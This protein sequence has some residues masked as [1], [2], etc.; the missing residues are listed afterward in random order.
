MGDGHHGHHKRA[1][2]LFRNQRNL[3]I[4]FFS[5]FLWLVLYRLIDLMRQLV[6]TRKALKASAGASN[7]NVSVTD[8]TK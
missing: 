5:L 1:N 6:E 3:Y 8:K 7:S 2:R 4:S